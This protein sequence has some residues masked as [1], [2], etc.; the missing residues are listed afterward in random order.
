M[1]AK[2]QSPLHSRSILPYLRKWVLILLSL[3]I[4]VGLGALAASDTRIALWSVAAIGG[5]IFAWLCLERPFFAFLIMMFFALNESLSNIALTG[6]VSLMVV[7]GFAFA[8][9]WILQIVTKRV[10]FIT[11]KQYWPLLGLAGIV[12]ISSIANWHG[13]AELR[14]ILTYTQQFLLVFLIV[15]F[16]TS[17]ERFR[18]L[19]FV[20]ILSSFSIAL[21]MVIAKLGG[22]SPS[23]LGI[24]V[25]NNEYNMVPRL[26]GYF[27]DPNFT[28]AQLLFAVPFIVELMPGIKGWRLRTLLL[29]AG[30]MILLASFLTYSTGG[31]I[32]LFIYFLFKVIVL[33]HSNLFVKIGRV[34]LGIVVTFFMFT[35]SPQQY[36]AKIQSNVSDLTNFIYNGN[37]A[38]LSQF[39]D[40][41]GG[42]WQAAYQTI[43]SSP[44]IGYGPG[45]GENAQAEHFINPVLQK[46]TA[47]HNMFLNVAE[48]LGV[49]GL[50][51]FVYLCI[52]SWLAIWPRWGK[53][54]KTNSLLQAENNAILSAMTI[55][56][57]VGISID[58]NLIKFSWA[59][60]GMAIV[61]TRF[62]NSDVQ[63]TNDQ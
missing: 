33:S 50:I 19:G 10:V 25:S 54:K 51:L 23:T 20:I 8:F 63:A 27:G 40:A 4:A 16:V 5:I 24:G 52:V 26:F 31:F 22:V 13:T 12:L 48:D 35:I 62:S 17:P 3:P 32:A 28:C 21:P 18:S 14:S 58:I 30:G 47:A 46:V 44:F 15:N 45:M 39:G 38:S 60:I 11:V 61:F 37:S 29:V 56:L 59:L 34:A 1:S 6:T 53:Q 41:R 49:F 43:V 7:L 2:F 55:F 42:A 57:V 36:Q 9:I